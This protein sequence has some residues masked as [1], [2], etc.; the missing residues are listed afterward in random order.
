MECSNTEEV[1]NVFRF[2]DMREMCIYMTIF[3]RTLAILDILS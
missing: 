1:L 2:D 3:S